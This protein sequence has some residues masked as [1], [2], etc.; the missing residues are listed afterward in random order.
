MGPLLLPAL[1]VA[2]RHLHLLLPGREGAGDGGA[3]V[4]SP[5]LKFP[6]EGEELGGGH[7]VVADVLSEV[8]AES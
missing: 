4:F 1:P 2:G 6:G 8:V 3:A 5:Q 7:E